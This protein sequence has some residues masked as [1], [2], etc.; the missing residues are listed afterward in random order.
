MLKIETT[1]SDWPNLLYQ[2]DNNFIPLYSSYDP[3]KQNQI[4]TREITKESKSLK[5]G[6]KILII[7]CGLFYDFENLMDL[8]V[9]WMEPFLQDIL[10]ALNS[11]SVTIN[12]SDIQSDVNVSKFRNN[13]HL[14]I[15]KITGLMDVERIFSRMDFQKKEITIRKIII[16]PFYRRH[17][18][19][20]IE[21]LI[22][23]I[24][25]RKG[26]GD[27]QVRFKKTQA[28]FSE[29]WLRNW[30]KNLQEL[31][32][33]PSVITDKIP[34]SGYLFHPQSQ[35]KSDAVL[36]AGGPGLEH[37]KDF[38]PL[39]LKKPRPLI[40]CIDTAVP[41][42]IRNGITPDLIVTI[43]SGRG[44][45]YH[46]LDTINK[47]QVPLLTWTC[48]NRNLWKTRKIKF[49][50]YASSFPMDQILSYL[51]PDLCT[52]ENPGGNVLT[53]AVNFYYKFFSGKLHIF[54]LDMEKKDYSLRS[55]FSGSAYEN[56]YLKKLN[57]LN[58]LENYNKNYKVASHYQYFFSSL[59][60]ENKKNLYVHH[61]PVF[62]KKYALPG[63]DC[64]P[65]PGLFTCM[66]KPLEECVKLVSADDIRDTVIKLL[67][68]TGYP[69]FKNA[70]ETINTGIT[71]LKKDGI[72]R[73]NII[74]YL[75]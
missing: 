27:T 29:L 21:P 28:H 35:I 17:L 15:K 2:I 1:R 57:R 10:D 46:F 54:G 49:W 23:E 26:P 60:D 51:F 74:R 36:L 70:I 38:Y 9:L 13:I 22:Q 24:A 58:S 19:I 34:Y 12:I 45:F 31:N 3:K 14:T 37:I 63:D 65:G 69:L 48:A 52:L 64:S 68:K 53:L 20:I 7:G 66:D 16:H 5:K 67:L 73:K 47:I 40:I 25:G 30:F 61:N 4:F 72:S 55:H 59:P 50:L 43:D 41:F 6:E 33:R 11:A 75:F 62:S 42:I 39:I 71:D 18:Q 56:Q 32:C 44:T 8:P